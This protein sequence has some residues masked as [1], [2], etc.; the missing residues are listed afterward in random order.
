VS[1]LNANTFVNKQRRAFAVFWLTCRTKSER[2]VETRA[3]F[4]SSQISH[5]EYCW[6]L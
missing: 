4:C 1:W 2:E 6:K 5:A 3:R